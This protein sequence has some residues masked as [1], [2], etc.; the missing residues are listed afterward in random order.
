MDTTTPHRSWTRTPKS[1]SLVYKRFKISKLEIYANQI[2][3]QASIHRRKKIKK[4]NK[5]KGV[6]V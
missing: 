1:K 2:L 4:I 6:P 3:A 5:N